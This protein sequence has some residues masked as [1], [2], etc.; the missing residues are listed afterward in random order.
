MYSYETVFTYFLLYSSI[1]NL[2]INSIF[3]LFII[4][5]NYIKN[6]TN[7]NY[8]N[9]SNYSKLIFV[10][11]LFSISGIPPFLFFFNKLNFFFF[12]TLLDFKITVFFYIFFIISIYFYISILRHSL[13]NEKYKLI[14]FFKFFLYSNYYY[15]YVLSLI[16]FLNTFGVFLLDD[17]FLIFTFVSF[18]IKFKI[19]PNRFSNLKNFRSKWLKYLYKLKFLTFGQYGIKILNYV[20]LTARHLN[21]Y[22]QLMQLC[23]RKGSFTARSMWVRFNLC[24]PLTKKP[25][26][27]RMGSGKG[28]LYA[29]GF[30]TFGGTIFFEVKNVNKGRSLNF[31]NQLSDCLNCETKFI[32]YT[33]K[34][35][36]TLF[37]QKG[38]HINFFLNMLYL[39]LN[40]FF[41]IIFIFFSLNYIFKVFFTLK[42]FIT[43]L[44][45]KISF[46]ILLITFFLIINLFQTY[47]V[48]NL[49]NNILWINNYSYVNFYYFPFI[50]IFILITLISI[51]FCL[52]YNYMELNS[53][54]IYISIIIF[55]GIN[56][57]LTD[58]ILILFY[59]YECLLVP[60]F[61]ILYIFSKTRRSVEAAYLMFFWTQFGALWLIFALIY[62]YNITN[63]FIFT[64]ITTFN[65]SIF[66]NYVVFICLLFG[67]GVKLPIWPFYEWLPKA[68]VEAST[69]FSIF[70]SG[71][72]VKFAFFG[73]FK[74]LFILNIDINFFFIFPYLT[75]GLFDSVF[76]MMYQVDIKKLVAYSTVI[77]MHWLL[78]CLFN[79]NNVLFLS[80]FGMYISH[81]LLSTNSFL[82]VDSISR[83]F[84][85]RLIYEISGINFLC[86]KL[87]LSILINLIVFLGFPGSIF[88]ISEFLFFSFLFDLFPLFCIILLFLIYFLLANFFIKIWS[89]VL[90]SSINTSIIRIPNDADKIELVI[91]FFLIILLFWLGSSWLSFFF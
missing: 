90:F 73:F 79:G 27:S 70:L 83:R 1:Y 20:F 69:N 51:I 37:L 42:L 15:L 18:Y 29:W 77:E 47:Y 91:F 25:K 21:R 39:N 30:K 60:S 35:N 72:L 84:K 62:I 40:Y 64:S 4:F 56:L 46:I 38:S 81:A 58:S 49:I 2:N 65:F 17:L 55:S 10:I 52:N 24:I 75:Y 13:V 12:L 43:G 6:I 3:F 76:K 26:G 31:F 33:I 48:Y 86:P 44:K 5:N 78:I 11:T 19:R 50:F 32:S 53:F 63:S 88:F 82:M 87:F 8:L 16:V 54:L 28:K 9:N 68:H 67:F 85:T 34:P 45:E 41:F 59:F 7:L 66:D 89:N 74:C 57:L 71:V 80:G 14:F 23:V 36:K 61:F 22:K